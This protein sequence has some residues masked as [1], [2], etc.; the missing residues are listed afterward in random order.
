MG[1][2]R[3]LVVLVVVGSVLAPGS[4]VGFWWCCG[5]AQTA[6]ESV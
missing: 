5:V 1:L 4:G 2:V 3:V 6:G